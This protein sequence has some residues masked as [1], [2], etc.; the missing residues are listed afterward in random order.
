MVDWIKIKS[1]L[2]ADYKKLTFRAKD[3]HIMKV[4]EYKK[5]FHANGNYRKTGVAILISD[6]IDFKTKSITKDKGY[7]III[8]SSIQEEHITYNI[9]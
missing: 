7:Y 2:K 5:I 4:R 1:H 9:Y 3:T 8:K 6:K